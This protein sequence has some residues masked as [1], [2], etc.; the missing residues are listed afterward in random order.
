LYECGTWSV[1]LIEELTLSV[2]EKW[3]LRKYFDQDEE[4]DR[5]VGKTA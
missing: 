5:R 3:V 2:L 1:T 4:G